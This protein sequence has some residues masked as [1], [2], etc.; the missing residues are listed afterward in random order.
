MDY[1]SHLPKDA[2]FWYQDVARKLDMNA[3]SVS[4]VINQLARVDKPGLRAG[5]KAGWYKVTGLPLVLPNSESAEKS[6][7][8]NRLAPGALLEVVG[9]LKG[10]EALL[11][12]PDSG[13]VWKA[14]R[15]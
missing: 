7:E 10:G 6:D 9:Y 11:R 1:L 14:V 5:G 12:D 15:M 2:E 8:E 4:T 3:T 13:E